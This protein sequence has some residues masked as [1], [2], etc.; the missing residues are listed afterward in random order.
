MKRLVLLSLTISALALLGPGCGAGLRLVPTGPQPETA[1]RAR[2]PQPPPPP[3]VEVIPLAK[4]P[5]CA[6]LDGHYERRGQGWHWEK[7]RWVRPPRGCY[8]A[9]G[10]TLYEEG[11]SGVELI[12]RPPGWYPRKKFGTCAAVAP[13]ETAAPGAK[14]SARPLVGTAGSPAAV[15]RSL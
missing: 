15:R 10:T 13:C 9:R 8:F 5:E 14:A 1:P 3:E 7:G 6:W 12:H 2:V 4:H 11:S